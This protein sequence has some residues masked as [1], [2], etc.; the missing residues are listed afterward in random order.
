MAQPSPSHK[1]D[2]NMMDDL[3]ESHPSAIHLCLALVKDL[4]LKAAFDAFEEVSC[5]K[6]WNPLFRL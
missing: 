1:A 4:M 5:N 2:D 3:Q 6:L